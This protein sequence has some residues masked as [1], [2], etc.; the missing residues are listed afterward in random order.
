MP[1]WV[2]HESRLPDIRGTAHEA[3]VV[4]RDWAVTK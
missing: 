2:I 1:T 3:V 4:H